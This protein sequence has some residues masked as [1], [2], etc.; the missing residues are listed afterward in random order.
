MDI[1]RHLYYVMSDKGML[2]SRIDF[3][4]Q[5]KEYGN[6]VQVSPNGKNLIF[7]DPKNLFK[8]HLLCLSSKQLLHV[9]S[10]EVNTSISQYILEL[11]LQEGVSFK[12]KQDAQL[13][14]KN[15]DGDFKAF[16]I[17]QNVSLFFSIND[18]LD[19]A[20]QITSKQELSIYEELQ[21]AFI[22]EDIPT[23]CQYLSCEEEEHTDVHRHRLSQE[24]KATLRH[25]HPVLKMRIKAS[26]RA[27]KGSIFYVQK[28]GEG[29]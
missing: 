7:Q 23:L 15:Y 12:D 18:N 20:V 14:R 2:L 21:K 4:E 29:L 26:V 25:M 19:V 17:E 10:I 22:E 1:D 27:S 24:S 8:I 6:P 5:V 16:F 9:K 13:L 28:A 3:S 11:E